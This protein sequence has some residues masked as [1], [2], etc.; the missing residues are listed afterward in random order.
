MAYTTQPE[1]GRTEL[2]VSDAVSRRL[3]EAIYLLLLQLKAIKEEG[4]PRHSP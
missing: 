4:R 3:L 2:L 1:T